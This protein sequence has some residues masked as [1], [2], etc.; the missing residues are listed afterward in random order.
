[1]RRLVGK[2]WL[3]CVAVA[4]VLLLGIA[5]LLYFGADPYHRIRKGMTPE[6]TEK[7]VG[8]G[9]FTENGAGYCCTVGPE[10]PLTGFGVHV[11]SWDVVI[12]EYRRGRLVKKSRQIPPVHALWDWS[13]H[14]AG[15]RSSAVPPVSVRIA[16][17]LGPPPESE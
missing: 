17:P 13:L 9:M 15:L 14:R 3:W 1:M 4:A 12:T 16:L 5:P 6:E 8:P 10:P 7:L 11:R 2:R